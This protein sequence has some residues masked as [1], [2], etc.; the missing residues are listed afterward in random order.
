[1]ITP[2]KIYLQIQEDVCGEDVAFESLGE[3]TWCADR[4][5]DNDVEYVRADLVQDLREKLEMSMS[6]INALRAKIE[7]LETEKEKRR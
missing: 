6:A 5:F 2:E 3:C 4:L 7:E 1:M